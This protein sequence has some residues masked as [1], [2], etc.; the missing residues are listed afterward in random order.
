MSH[1]FSEWAVNQHRDSIASYIGHHSMLEYFALAEGISAGRAKLNL[2]E[3]M[4]RPCGER[5]RKRKLE[6]VDK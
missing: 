5:P 4:I 3:R 1:P 2:L 6:E